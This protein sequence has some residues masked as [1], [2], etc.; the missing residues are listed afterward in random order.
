MWNFSFFASMRFHKFAV[1]SFFANAQKCLLSRN[2]SPFQQKEKIWAIH[3]R[4]E[5]CVKRFV[6]LMHSS[7]PRFYRI[8]HFARLVCFE[9]HPFSAPIYL[10]AHR[11]F[12]QMPPGKVNKSAF[13]CVQCST[14]RNPFQPLNHVLESE[15]LINKKP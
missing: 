15:T 4:Q 1:H 13:M 9:L 10:R 14:K 2:L 3:H 7:A 5:I 12:A 8:S 11:L 6:E